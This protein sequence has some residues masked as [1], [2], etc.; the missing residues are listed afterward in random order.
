MDGESSYSLAILHELEFRAYAIRPSHWYGYVWL[1]GFSSQESSA[2]ALRREVISSI[3]LEYLDRPG[4]SATHGLLI[5]SLNPNLRIA[6]IG[7]L[8]SGERGERHV[9]AVVETPRPSSSYIGAFSRSMG[10]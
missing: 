8:L 3:S 7:H 9:G 2:G 6:T 5:A 4:P 1:S 10:S